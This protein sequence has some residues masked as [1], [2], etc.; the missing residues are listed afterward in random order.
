VT[1]RTPDFDD[2][3][4]GEVEGA[5]RERFRRVHD[6]LVS[7][8]PP[9]ELAS[10]AA[11]A[12]EAPPARLP[13]RRRRLLLALA[14]ALGVAA[15][16]TVGL[17]VASSDEP[18]AER[19]VA[20]SGPSGASASLEIFPLD[21]AGNWPM[22]IDVENLP[23]TRGGQLF[24]LWLTKDGKPAALCGSFLTDD[25]GRAV[26]PMNAPWRVDDFD[27]W[28]VVEAGSTTPLLTT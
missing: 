19:V 18:S 16:F 15:V 12:T 9:P 23:P 4:G 2:L 27:G 21:D 14:A 10:L 22:L 8:G 13:L 25:D 3:V 7:A 17:L 5:E 6:L 26:V 28:V 20:M 24:Q 1:G 11:P